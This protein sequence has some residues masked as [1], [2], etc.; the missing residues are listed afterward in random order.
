MKFFNVENLSTHLGL[1]DLRNVSF[2]LD[3]GDY[4][5]I[6]GPTGS[7]K[8]IFLETII[9]FYKPKD[10][11]I[12][13]DGED[14]T[15]KPPQNR[16]I[17]IV[18]QDYAL[19]PHMNIYDNIA[20]GLKKRQ[21]NIDKKLRDMANL[22]HIG[23]LLKRKPE[24][25]S[26]GEQQRV[27]LARAFVVEPK[28]LLMDEPMSALDFQTRKE[29]RRIIK[30]V[31]NKTQMTVIHVTHDLED[32]WSM[33]NKVAIFKEG[34]AIQFGNIC[35][36]INKPNSH[37]VADFVGTTIFEGKVETTNPLTVIDIGGIKLKSMDYTEKK[38]VKIAIRPDDIVIS[39]NEPFKISAQ[40]I[41]KTKV[42]NIVSEGNVCII[43]L[44]AKD[45]IF[46][47]IITKNAV[48]SLN[49]NWGDDV[50]AVIKSSNV[51]I[52]DNLI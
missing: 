14:I 11:R 51:R 22:L 33:A 26:G 16:N 46:D 36:V 1:F 8:T 19:F 42:E 21:N 20:Y 40:N 6:I 30:N 10:G 32:M 4:L 44:K 9:G 13:M 7:G 2:S 31:I 28:L 48:D 18:Y 34:K 25:L 27:A 12:Y 3:K 45:I 49:I 15:D 38:T 29:V 43:S 50:Y 17:G 5:S 37:F 47:V 35:D 52:I 41:I 24:T 39:K 23:R